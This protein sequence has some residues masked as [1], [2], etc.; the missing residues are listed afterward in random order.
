[1][2]VLKS[3]PGSLQLRKCILCERSGQESPFRTSPNVEA[4]RR[5]D[6]YMNLDVSAYFLLFHRMSHLIN[7]VDLDSQCHRPGRNSDLR[8]F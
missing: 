5:D 6:S 3:V 1:M 2:Y 7:T 8:D 4:G